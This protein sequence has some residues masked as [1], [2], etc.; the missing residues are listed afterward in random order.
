MRELWNRRRLFISPTGADGTAAGSPG[1]GGAE[2]PAASSGSMAGEG[3]GSAPAPNLAPA[4]QA[5]SGHAPSPIGNLDALFRQL[6]GGQS[7]A[8][9]PAAASAPAPAQGTPASAAFSVPETDDDLANYP[10]QIREQLLSHRQAYRDLNQNLSTLRQQVDTFRP[11]ERYG[12]PEAIEQRLQILEG[13]RA[14]VTDA[15]GR[16]LYDEQT[17]LPLFTAR[18]GLEALRQQSPLMLAQVFDDLRSME[19]LPGETF[20]D[21]LLRE[22]G[23]DPSRVD[24]YRRLHQAG[25]AAQLPV[26]DAELAD[27]PAEYHDA[28]KTLPPNVRRDFINQPDSVRQDIL[29][30]AQE[31]LERSRQLDEIQ[32]WRQQ[33]MEAEVAAFQR[34]L[35]QSQ[36]AYITDLRTQTFDAIQKQIASQF[37]ASSDPQVSA[38]YHGIV[39]SALGTLLD[40]ALRPATAQMLQG[41]GVNVGR[42]FEEAIH[43]IETQAATYKRLESYSQSPL[44]QAYRDDYQMAQARSAVEQARLSVQATLNNAAV[45]LMEVLGQGIKR[46]AQEV[47][48]RLGGRRVGLPS[49]NGAPESA[50]APP[51]SSGRP[52]NPQD[53]AKL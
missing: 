7:A 20:Q 42:E 46:Q 14:P 23:L 6:G 47:D 26:T 49:L 35:E 34:N 38:V 16:L 2:A 43:T 41:L 44:Y 39:M 45:K 27:V 5:E 24:E 22:I 12:Q 21:A 8:P 32:Q 17:R 30:Y 18:P 3:Q 4:P 52:F 25:Q 40:P 33:Q 1:G 9:A 10:P 28:F 13:L 36:V 50:G 15:Q 29:S 11:L 51:V 19:F 37:Q 48:A 53:Y 31:Q